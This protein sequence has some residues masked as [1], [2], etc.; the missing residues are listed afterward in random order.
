[1]H[2]ALAP[3]AASALLALALGAG[4]A[5]AERVYKWVDEQGV[6]HYSQTPP[7]GVRAT[8]LDVATGA[9]GGGEEGGDPLERY[10]RVLSPPKKPEKAAD[11]IDPAKEAEARARN[12]KVARERLAVL[13]A[14]SR[15]LVLKPDG[16]SERLT[17]EQRQAEIKRMKAIIA[18]N[19]ED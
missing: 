19:C 11:G 4:A 6:T 2:R 10:R 8:P 14:R 3:A 1:M 17:E 5:A 7:A 16:T 15:I 12:C 9:P 13:T 18:A